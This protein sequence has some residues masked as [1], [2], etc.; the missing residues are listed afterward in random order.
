MHSRHRCRSYLHIFF[1]MSVITFAA[2]FTHHL[3][4][5]PLPH[6]PPPC[7]Y[8]RVHFLTFRPGLLAIDSLEAACVD[9][10]AGCVWNA[11]SRECYEDAKRGEG[12]AVTTTIA[13]ATA[14]AEDADADAAC[15]AHKQGCLE[16]P[17]CDGLVCTAGFG[18]TPSCAAA[19]PLLG[20]CFQGSHICNVSA[21]LLQCSM[22]QWWRYSIPYTVAAGGVALEHAWWRSRAY[23]PLLQKEGVVCFFNFFTY[24]ALSPSPSLPPFLP[25]C[26]MGTSAALGSAGLARCV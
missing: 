14:A 3:Y 23:A 4:M 5:P 20:K 19:D 17:C 12:D 1:C 24:L 9:S 26:S 6:P 11:D 7:A 16:L 21:C 15:S 13:I 10:L 25:P 2:P 18:G 8:T 22:V